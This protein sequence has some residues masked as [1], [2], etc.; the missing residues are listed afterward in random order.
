MSPIRRRC[1]DKKVGNANIGHGGEISGFK[2]K[3]LRKTGQKTPGALHFNPKFHRV[4][5]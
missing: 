4:E 3:T 1:E 2:K 5:V